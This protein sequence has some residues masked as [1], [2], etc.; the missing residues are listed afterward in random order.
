[1]TKLKPF[2]LAASYTIGSHILPGASIDNIREL[3]EGKLKLTIL[4]CNEIIDGVQRGIFDIGLIES[5]LY[6]K[7]L[8]YKEWME[9]EMIVCSKRALPHSLNE[10]MLSSCNLVC[11]TKGSLTRNFITEVLKKLGL[12]Y[13]TFNSLTE[14]DNPTAMIQSIKWAKPN[15]DHPTVAI[16]SQLAIEDE[17]KYND[18]YQSRIC[19]QPMT[20]KFH[21]IYTKENQYDHALNELINQLMKS[22]S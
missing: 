12:S 1:M 14:V 5:P 17:L 19:N 7:S 21:L 13:Q 2:H 15:V 8:I 18:L 20:R 3:V 11:R 9:D 4:P 16:V 22:V 10:E 6:D